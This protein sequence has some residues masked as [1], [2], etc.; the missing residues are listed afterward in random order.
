M[1]MRERA[2]ILLYTETYLVLLKRALLLLPPLR[3]PPP[4]LPSSPPP[5]FSLPP[6]DSPFSFGSLSQLTDL[7]KD[8]DDGSQEI[9]AS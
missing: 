5:L 4:Q 6:L 9:S 8:W 7:L 3:S 2:V 1:F